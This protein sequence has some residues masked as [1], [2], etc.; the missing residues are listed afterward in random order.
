MVSTTGSRRRRPSRSA[1]AEPFEDAMRWDSVVWSSHC[2][3]CYPGNCPFRAYVRDGVIW[4]EEQAGTYDTIEAGV[5]DMNPMGCQKGAGWSFTHDGAERIRYPMRRA[6]PRGSG[7]WERIS[8]DDA[9]DGIADAIIDAIEQTGPESVMYETSPAQGGIL[10]VM[11]VA[12]FVGSLGGIAIDLEGVINDFNSGMYLTYGKFNV[13]SVDDWFHADRLLIW[14]MNPAYTRIPFFHY[15]AEARYRGARV[16]MIAPDVNAS[17]MHADTYVPVRPGAD[18]ALA[19]AMCRVVIDEG[20]YD[21]RFVREQTDMPLLVRDDTGRFL[22]E[23][24]LRNGGRDDQFFALDEKTGK[25]VPANRGSLRWGR[26]IPA[27]ERGRRVTLADGT[28]VRVRPVFARL[29]EH[30]RAYSP[31]AASASCGTHPD[32]IRSLARD[33]AKAKTSILLGF[34]SCKYYHCDLMERSMLLFLA[35]T[36]NWGKKGTGA[37][38]WSA[39]PFDGPIIT[40]MKTSPD[41]EGARRVLAQRRLALDAMKAADPTLTDELATLALLSMIPMHRKVAPA[42]LLLRRYGGY[43]E[44]WNRRAWGDP[45][46]PRPFE[47]YFDDATHAGWWSGV[48]DG[49]VPPRVFVEVGGNVL[50]RTRGGQNMLLEHFWPRLTMAVTIDFHMTTT[51]LQ[52]DIVLP[53]ANHGEKLNVHY[54]TPHVMQVLLAD[55]AVEPAAEAKPEWEIF[56][57]LARRVTQRAEARGL[58]SFKDLDGAVRAYADIGPQFTT[59]DLYRCEERL[60]EEWIR[61][62]A[63]AGN[64]PKDT[65]LAALRRTGFVRV[66]DWG[67]SPLAVGQASEIRRDETHVPNRDHV[68]KRYPYP[69][70]TR[71]AQFYI[72]HP[73]FLEAGEALPAHK[74]TPAMGGN[75]PLQ[76]T[77]GHMRWSIHSSNVT[78]RLMLNTHRGAPFIFVSPADAA[79]RGVG[80]GD[81]IRVFNDMGEFYVEAK[82]APGVRPGQVVMYN[83]WDPAQFRGWR[84]PMDVEPGMVKPLHLAGGYGHV[85][86]RPGMWQPVPVDRATRV[87]FER[88]ATT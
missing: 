72:D 23:S 47:E 54:A 9:L 63:A 79:A 26:A 25:I 55:K 69:T 28:A 73:W 10:G 7:M 46:L 86:Y 49:S 68:E 20:L 4:R 82:L 65:T 2:V 80:D 36:G 33:C 1:E 70:L 58:T 75:L 30:L 61:D 81:L 21:T 40:A 13:S 50:R 6:G 37:R 15:I 76:M 88:A 84:G 5:P 8:W 17:T 39:G 41:V 83:G 52:S 57:A 19:L 77:S 14:H 87:D 35:L 85:G 74:E 12:R 53:A 42:F 56:Q 29:R 34:N 27:L 22:R 62:S 51:A 67:M 66:E 18:A 71:R 59:G 44:V 11:S 3:D 60:V 16:Y 38:S 64:I 45:T 32:L 31:E 24:D 78:T 43:G 48:A